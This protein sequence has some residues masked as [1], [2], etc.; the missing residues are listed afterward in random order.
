MTRKQAQAIARKIRRQHLNLEKTRKLVQAFAKGYPSLVKSWAE[1]SGQDAKSMWKGG[2]MESELKQDFRNPNAFATAQTIEKRKRQRRHASNILQQAESLIYGP[3]N[4]V[5][6][7]PSENFENI[8]N[9]WNAY[10]IAIGRRKGTF[11]E[12]HIPL[13]PTILKDN[14]VQ[15]E[16]TFQINMIDVAM[17]NIL[18]KIARCATAQDHEDTVVDIAGYAGCVER[19]VK[20]K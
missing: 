13:S 4:A 1:G 19:I 8:A 2:L 18:Q 14:F 9:L 17:C 5:Y 16:Q 6:K 15:K 3:R 7:H 20:N 10:F 11:G 12:K